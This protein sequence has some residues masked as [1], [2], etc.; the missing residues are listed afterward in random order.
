ASKEA[1]VVQGRF[2]RRIAQLK[3]EFDRAP[4]LPFSELLTESRIANV[5]N[6]LNVLY[7]DRIY[8]PCVTLWVFLSQVLAEDH[9]CRNAVARLL[10]FRTQ[11]GLGSCSTETG[12]YCQARRRLPEELVQRLARQTGKE[13]YQQ[14]PAAWHLHG[15]PVKN[16][17]GAT[18]SMPDTLAN[19]QA[20]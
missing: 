3:S 4:A 7:R 9:S 6:E 18:V 13:I 15:R 1:A 14:A 19:A 12:S 20:F 11:Q 2:F 10:A 5:F 8:P 16:V 17:D